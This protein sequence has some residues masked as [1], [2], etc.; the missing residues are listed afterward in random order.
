MTGNAVAIASSQPLTMPIAGAS[1]IALWTSGRTSVLSHFGSRAPSPVSPAVGRDHATAPPVYEF[2]MTVDNQPS[3]EYDERGE[4]TPQRRL[5][6]AQMAAYCLHAKRDP[7]ETTRAAFMDRFERQ[8]DPDRRLPEAER[9]RRA[10]AARKAH[11][12]KLALK[13]AEVRRRRR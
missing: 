3:G 10:D 11:F 7:V 12:I 9:R 4:L 6:R 8:V 2:A 13:S 5:L 1:T